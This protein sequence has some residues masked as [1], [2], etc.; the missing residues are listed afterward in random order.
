MVAFISKPST[1]E[2]DVG[3]LKASICSI[4]RFYLWKKQELN[5]LKNNISKLYWDSV[6]CTLPRILLWEKHARVIRNIWKTSTRN[7]WNVRTRARLL[8]TVFQQ[9]KISPFPLSVRLH[10]GPMISPHPSLP[11]HPCPRMIS[12]FFMEYL[13]MMPMMGPPHPLEVISMRPVPGMNGK[14]FVH[15]A[16]ASNDKTSHLCHDDA[17]WT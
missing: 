15:D 3:K 2:T 1:F 6:I 9:G 13:P 14:P 17:H 12:S 8:L 7:G 11:G 10:V 4:A 5:S 16:Q